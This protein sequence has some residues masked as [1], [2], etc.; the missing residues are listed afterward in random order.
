M[1]RNNV[2]ALY[3]MRDV[4]NVNPD[5]QR[6]GDVWNSEK[7]QLLIDTIINR[8][9]VPKIYLHKY[10]RP[11]EINGKLYEYSIIDGKQ[12]LSTIWD[13]I[14]G[15]FPLA[16]DFEYF[17]DKTVQIGGMTYKDFSS[18]YPDIKSDFDSF[19]LIVVEVETDDIEMIEEMFSR[20]NEA[21]ALNAP[22]KR[23]AYGGPIP[24]SV[25]DLC[26]MDF[27]LDKLPFNNS[28][29][30]HFDLATKFLYAVE[31]NKIVET[32]KIFLDR[33]VDKYAKENREEELK[34]VSDTKAIVKDMSGVF[35]DK[36][37]LLRSTGMVMLY[38]YLFKWAREQGW[39]KEVERTKLERFE[40]LR[41]DNRDL[42]KNDLAKADYDL[43]QFDKYT[44]SPN[45]KNALEFRLE[46][47]LKTIFNKRINPV[48]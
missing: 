5:Y 40:K 8:F 28:R 46:I 16:T 24:K 31:A 34:F 42:A 1:A 47:L 44:Q 32:K 22:E 15:K 41:A 19:P 23:N 45:D 13:F 9:D 17:G 29:Y 37:S 35:V 2:W 4:I 18:K 7:K 11:E 43:I 12:R 3:R 14:D 26:N 21:V 25:R 48:A 20:L 33:F 30:R 38:F 10:T 39:L 36:D 27:F 6:H